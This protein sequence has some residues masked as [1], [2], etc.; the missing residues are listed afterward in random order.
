[1]GAGA[2]TDYDGFKSKL[3]LYDSEYGAKVRAG[4]LTAKDSFVFFRK[5]LR[6]TVL[7]TSNDHLL[8][9]ISIG[10]VRDIIN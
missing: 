7:H 5:S 3:D 4:D 9:A 6:R 1:M 8:P 2:S 10:D